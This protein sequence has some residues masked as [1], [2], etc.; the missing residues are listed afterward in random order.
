M[1]CEQGSYSTNQHIEAI[2]ADSNCTQTHR[3]PKNKLRCIVCPLLQ[4]SYNFTPWYSLHKGRVGQRCVGLKCISQ[5]QTSLIVLWGVQLAQSRWLLHSTISHIGKNYAQKATQNNTNKQPQSSAEE[6]L[7]S[8]QTL[9]ISA[10]PL[11]Q[12]ETSS[13]TH[14]I[15]VASTSILGRLESLC[16]RCSSSKRAAVGFHGMPMLL[17]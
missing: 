1:T 9:Q 3:S 5:Q 16:T 6:L 13:V 10:L 12:I 4:A 7:M 8:W 15:P 11:L 2:A 17:S 14:Y